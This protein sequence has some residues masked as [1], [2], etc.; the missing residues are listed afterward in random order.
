MYSP[1][2]KDV[3]GNFISEICMILLLVLHGDKHNT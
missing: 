1:H 3:L 2:Y